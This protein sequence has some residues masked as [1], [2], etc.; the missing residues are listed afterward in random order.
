[1][2]EGSINE[3]EEKIQEGLITEEQYLVLMKQIGERKAYGIVRTLHEPFVP[4]SSEEIVMKNRK[5]QRDNVDTLESVR[6][7]FK[8]KEVPSALRKHQYELLSSEQ[9]HDFP[10]DSII[11]VIGHSDIRKKT[12]VPR[13]YSELGDLKVVTLFGTEMGTSCFTF[14][15]HIV[16][17]FDWIKHRLK[18]HYVTP[19]D[20]VIGLNT[21]L[22]E[23]D[24]HLETT[25]QDE[26]AVPFLNS[27]VK[28]SPSIDVYFNKEW[29]F[30]E[31]EDGLCENSGS[32]YFYKQDGT[33]GSL[34]E[35]RE[36]RGPC[37]QPALSKKTILERAVA[38]GCRRPLFIDLGCNTF[39][40]KGSKAKWEKLK[41]RYGH[42]G[43]RK[44]TK[45]PKVKKLIHFA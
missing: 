40:G 7:K 30:F 37:I 35:E 42:I 11:Y 36:R 5:Q 21:T 38:L 32:V 17:F 43:G 20:I 6:K 45:R 10:W 25:L 16:T 12:L 1:M 18:T 3:V 27:G 13:H 9:Y 22:R 28:I 44:S 15:K 2:H 41:T 19:V 23:R 31:E 29:D 33:S 4:L 34:L 39:A 26:E 14:T 24:P 8:I